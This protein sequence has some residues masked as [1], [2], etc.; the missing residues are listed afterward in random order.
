MA[1][2]NT[3]RFSDNSYLVGGIHT[4]QVKL[5]QPLSHSKINLEMTTK[6][7]CNLKQLFSCFLSWTT[8]SPTVIRWLCSRLQIALFTVWTLVKPLT[9]DCN[10]RK[11]IHFY[12][13]VL[14]PVCRYLS[15]KELK[16]NSVKQMRI[17]YAQVQH[18][19]RKIPGFMLRGLSISRTPS[20]TDSW[21]RSRWCPS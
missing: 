7:Y 11:K 5:N 10:A 19:Y 13:Y 21:G 12:N 1:L 3:R 4:L 18:Y 17:H 8:A 16:T 2:F 20:K 9:I 6:L 15:S 14:V